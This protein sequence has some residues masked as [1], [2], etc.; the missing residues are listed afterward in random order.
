MPCP[1]PLIA[2]QKSFQKMPAGVTIKIIVDNQIAAANIERFLKTVGTSYTFLDQ[3]SDLLSI[4]TV[5]K[6]REERKETSVESKPI[7]YYINSDKMGRGDPDLGEMLMRAFLKNILHVVPKPKQIIFV[8]GG[9]KLLQEHQEL[10]QL[11]IQLR[12]EGI[13]IT[14]CGTCATFFEYLPSSE[15]GMLSNMYDIMMILQSHQVITP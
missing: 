4:I 13:S 10:E 9:V 3:S 12:K 2:V 11:V 8:N 5:V 7:A 15:V 14:I 1:E 6:K